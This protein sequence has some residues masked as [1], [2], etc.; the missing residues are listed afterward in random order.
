MKVLSTALTLD[1]MFH[2]RFCFS[3][4]VNTTAQKTESWDTWNEA[5]TKE[6]GWSTDWS[7]TGSGA[8]TTT[9]TGAS[10]I[11]LGGSTTKTTQG[12]SWNNESFTV[13][14]KKNQE[15]EDMWNSLAS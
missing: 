10:L 2:Q 6:E 5:A 4:S 14:E 1:K 13:K 11:D 9:G 8:P 12:D 3:A 7:G 15:E